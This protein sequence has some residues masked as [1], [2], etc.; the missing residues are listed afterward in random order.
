MSKKLKLWT[1][2][3][4]CATLVASA[5]T[6]SPQHSHKMHNAGPAK[7]LQLAD[8]SGGEGEGEGM[9]AAGAGDDVAF[10]V[11]LGL[12]EG[13]LRAGTTLYR[14]GEIDMCKTHIKH[15]G[16]EIYVDLKPLLDARGSKGF[17]AELDAVA[18]AVEAGKPSDEVDAHAATLFAAI[19]SIRP[20]KEAAPVTAVIKD[21]IRTAAEEYEIGVKGGKIDNVHEY[22]DAWGFTQTSKAML[23]GLSAE[24][25]TEHASEV[26]AIEA[27]LAVL[28]A[29]W[30]DLAGKAPVTGE[31]KTLFAAAAKIELI[32]LGMK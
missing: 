4:L 18:A 28:D 23:A 6:A 32:G 26:A 14:A 5:A 29:L 11:L 10:A 30:P 22:Q 21:L 7:H 25:K 27:E 1:G 31:A 24:A 13:H 8:A 19:D 3:G 16:D 17:A 2:L 20:T 15:P 9:S 12:V